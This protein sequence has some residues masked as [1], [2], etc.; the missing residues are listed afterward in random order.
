[1]TNSKVADLYKTQKSLT[2]WF[3]DI[4][5]SNINELRNE[6]NDKRDRLRILNE[7]IDLPYDKPTQFSASDIHNQTPE[8]KL[9]LKEHGEELCALRLM[10]KIEG[11]P[12]LRMRGKNILEVHEWFK[13][14]NIDHTNYAADFTPHS[15][16]TLWATIFVVNKHGIQGEIIK[17]GHH[18]L[19]QGFYDNDAPMTFRFNFNKWEISLNDNEA[20]AHLQKLI[21]FIHVTNKSKQ[22]EL[23]EKLGATFINDYIEG[24]FETTDSPMGTWYIDYSQSLGKMYADTIIRTSDII[25]KADKISGQ[26]GSPGKVKGKVVIVPTDNLQIPFAEGSIL[27]CEVTTPDYVPLM[28]KAAAIVTDQG[29]ILSHAAIIARELKKPCI[30]ST[31]DATKKLKNGQIVTVN[32]DKGIVE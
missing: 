17:G 11:L 5:H 13:E 20:L 4:K 14:Q 18:Q 32:A 28:Q 19:T 22:Q 23:H 9:F 27:V 10:P 7:I 12:K 16:N 8:F 21:K 15:P 3:E 1:M 24:Y 2:E 6:D 25:D 29:G 26:T 30:V 31:G